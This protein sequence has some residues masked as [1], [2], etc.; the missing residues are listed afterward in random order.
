L[1]STLARIG[2]PSRRSDAGVV[3]TTL[4][5]A[6][7]ADHVAALRARLPTVEKTAAILRAFGYAGRAYDFNFDFR[8]DAAMVGVQPAEYPKP[9]ASGA[10]S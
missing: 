10:V 8:T 9:R 3:F 1:P 5:H 4:D 6:G 7:G 2:A